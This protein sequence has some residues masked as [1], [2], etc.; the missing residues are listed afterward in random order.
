MAA[1]N[2]FMNCNYHYIK[3]IYLR[4]APRFRFLVN[5][6]KNSFL[7]LYEGDCFLFFSSAPL[8][9][10][11]L[12]SQKLV[13]DY[14]TFV[15]PVSAVVRGGV[16]RAHTR[17]WCLFF[18]HYL[19]SVLFHGVVFSTIHKSIHPL[20]AAGLMRL[21]ELLQEM[22]NARWCSVYYGRHQDGKAK[23][24]RNVKAKR[25]GRCINFNLLK[26]DLGR[27]WILPDFLVTF[28]QN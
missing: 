20:K 13:S 27:I 28:L 16:I 7:K 23:H 9:S 1:I 5:D 17:F 14:C 22:Q 2:S 4:R 8:T 24:K 26:L 3:R 6:R 19:L 21:D 10:F 18:S 11:F 15:C 12:S 25:P